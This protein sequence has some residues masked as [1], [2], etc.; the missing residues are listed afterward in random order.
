MSLALECYV[1]GLSNS[2]RLRYIPNQHNVVK[3]IGKQVNSEAFDW[4]YFSNWPEKL[5]KTLPTE[6]GLLRTQSYK[7]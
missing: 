1:P 5:V 3:A 4:S 7:D 6:A 2:M